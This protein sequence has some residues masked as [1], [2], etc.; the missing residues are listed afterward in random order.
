MLTTTIGMGTPIMV[1]AIIMIVIRVNL[2]PLKGKFVFTK[3]CKSHILFNDT[4]S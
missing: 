1:E 4:L 3:N 2:R